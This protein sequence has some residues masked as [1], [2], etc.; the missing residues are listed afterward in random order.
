MAIILGISTLF[1]V[2]N[3]KKDTPIPV[4]TTY[5]VT[6]V[7]KTTAT[8]GGEIT[9]EGDAPV[10]ERGVCWGTNQTPTI[11]DSKT[12]DGAGAGSF[13]SAIIG[14]IAN[15]KYY[16]RAYAT[17]SAG[18]GYGNVM[19]FTTGINFNPNITYGTMSDI[20]G[21]IYKT[22]TIGTQTWM[23]EN[24]KVTQYNDGSSIPNVTDNTAWSKLTTGALC[25][26]ENIALNSE[27]FGKLYNWYAVNSGKLA[28][29]GWHVPSDT[30]WTIL[31][32]YLGGVREAGAKLKETGTSHWVTNAEATNESGFTALPGGYRDSRG[33]F[34][35]I[36]YF[37]G[38][39]SATEKDAIRA[40][41]RHVSGDSRIFYE[42]PNLKE[43][44][45][46]VRCVKD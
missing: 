15:A 3:C 38:W 34:V 33:V 30:E 22:V 31:A 4:V 35:N 11:A 12:I 24:L 1:M 5:E 26:N 42:G 17:N 23:A 21:N 44:G 37:N 32:D 14:L 9:S 6:E 39:W 19:V 7:T 43:N 10:T 36:W 27:T 2:T 28:P 16:V 29:E 8:S 20:D 45:K 25:D 41:Y 18:T 13:S 46:S 40:L